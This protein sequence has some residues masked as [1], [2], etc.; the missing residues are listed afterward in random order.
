M[1]RPD[2]DR[3]RLGR[4]GRFLAEAIKVRIAVLQGFILVIAAMYVVIN[5]LVDVSYGLIDPRVRV[6]CRTGR[7]GAS[8]ELNEMSAT[9]E[10]GPD[11]DL[12]R[13]GA[14]RGG[15][16]L[17]KDAWRQLRRDPVTGSDSA[18]SPSLFSSR[19]SR[20]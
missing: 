13:L 3:V 17:A 19:Y 4:R 7:T 15:G 9:D 18:S 1:V 20:R 12:H 8:A 16:S 14:G 10:P 2:R 11:G 5:L 6:R